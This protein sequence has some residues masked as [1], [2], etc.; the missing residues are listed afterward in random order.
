M[1]VFR[2]FADNPNLPHWIDEVSSAME[3]LARKIGDWLGVAPNSP[4][5][6]IQGPTRSGLTLDDPAIQTPI[7]GSMLSGRPVLIAPSGHLIDRL[8]G[9]P[10]GSRQS[11]IYDTL[12]Q[13][14]ATPT[15]AAGF[16]GNFKQ[17]SGF[18]PMARRIDPRTGRPAGDQGIAQWTASRKAQFRKMFG[19]DPADAAPGMA[20]QEQTTFMIWELQHQYKG[21]ANAA[22][23]AQ[24]PEEAAW[25]AL[26][27]YEAGNP[28]D[29]DTSPQWELERA[30]RGMFAK[31]IAQP[32]ATQFLLGQRNLS[33]APVTVQVQINQN[34]SA[35]TST[36]AGTASGR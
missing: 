31:Q 15:A 13:N 17:E 16:L 10:A 23:A 24:T 11:Y 8:L 27:Y 36:A 6:A 22:N 29:W 30:R 19:H 14:G 21:A 2:A 28:K 4:S 35:V 5:G 26:R 1:N 3:R 20:M 18:D 34:T 7:P 9:V 25:A 33:P 32:G 12:V